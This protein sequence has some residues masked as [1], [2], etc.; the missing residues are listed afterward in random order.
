MP[1]TLSL[2]RRAQASR[3]KISNCVPILCAEGGGGGVGE[4]RSYKNL[5]L[6][7]GLTTTVHIKHY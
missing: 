6:V 3:C 7:Y 4:E 1:R 2:S 5:N